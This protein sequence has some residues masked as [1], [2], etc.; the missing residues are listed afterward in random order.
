MTETFTCPI[1]RPKFIKSSITYLKLIL[2]TKSKTDRLPQVRW[3]S[4]LNYPGPIYRYYLCVGNKIFLSQ[5]V[6]FLTFIHFIWLDPWLSLLTWLSLFLVKLDRLVLWKSFNGSPWTSQTLLLN[7]D[8]SWI[9]K[10][11]EV[12]IK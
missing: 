7:I 4:P 3:D 8:V 1:E 2:K 6:S 5:Y 9:I 12:Y 10:V 11:H